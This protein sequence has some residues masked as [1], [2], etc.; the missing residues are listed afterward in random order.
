MTNQENSFVGFEYMEVP[1][2]RSMESLYVDSYQNFGWVYEGTSEQE[3]SDR[4]TM[5]FKR[6]RKIRNKA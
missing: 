5:K 6:D 2:K 4:V 3:N 1:A